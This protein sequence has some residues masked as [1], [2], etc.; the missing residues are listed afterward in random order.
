MDPMSVAIT[1]L[2]LCLVQEEMSS[3]SLAQGDFLS[4][5]RDH[6]ARSGDSR[7]FDLDLDGCL[8]LFQ[9]LPYVPDLY[10][11]VSPSSVVSSFTIGTSSARRILSTL[12]QL[13]DAGTVSLTCIK[14]KSTLT[15]YESDRH[16]TE[17]TNDDG[18]RPRSLHISSE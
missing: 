16:H 15:H 5:V 1:A 11:S 2:L 4:F 9:K 6:F 18:K 8:Q 7:L 17:D 3:E 13:N 14:R 10:R 12:I